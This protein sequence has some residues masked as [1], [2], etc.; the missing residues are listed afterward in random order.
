MYN[1][2]TRTTCPVPRVREEASLFTV[3]LVM[4]ELLRVTE[5]VAPLQNPLTYCRL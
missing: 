5:P 3:L 2:H 4:S 1:Q